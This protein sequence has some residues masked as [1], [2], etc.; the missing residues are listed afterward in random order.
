MITISEKIC[1]AA[2][3]YQTGPFGR[4]CLVLDGEACQKSEIG[5]QKMKPLNTIHRPATI[6]KPIVMYVA[7]RKGF[8]RKM[9]MKRNK[10]DNLERIKARL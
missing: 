4:Q 7:R 1:M 10:A 6:K 3:E 9:R 2:L 5:M 8:V